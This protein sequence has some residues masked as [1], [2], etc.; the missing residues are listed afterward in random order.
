MLHV[1]ERKR[2]V[3]VKKK[4]RIIIIIIIAITPLTSLI[5]YADP[6]PSYHTGKTVPESWTK[7]S[8]L[9]LVRLWAA[10]TRPPVI[11]HRPYEPVQN[12]LVADGLGEPPGPVCSACPRAGQ[13]LT[14]THGPPVIPPPG[15][16][17]GP[18]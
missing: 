10:T 6:L 3:R 1:R 11:Q 16:H 15:P 2:V 14:S 5:E 4:G 7:T 17:R 9:P 12:G 13:R 18:A 8:T